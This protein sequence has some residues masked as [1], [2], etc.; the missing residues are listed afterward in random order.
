MI[1][2]ECDYDDRVVGV[3]GYRFAPVCIRALLTLPHARERTRQL[4]IKTIPEQ[5]Q[6]FGA[7]R[8][9]SGRTS[10]R[11]PV[12]WGHVQEFFDACVG[13]CVCVG[14]VG[15]GVRQRERKMRKGTD[16]EATAPLTRDAQRR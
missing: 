12:L 10:F 14:K 11:P 6:K 3:R 16:V 4:S 2:A 9:P 13:V 15:E 7:C 1:E 8:S 5:L